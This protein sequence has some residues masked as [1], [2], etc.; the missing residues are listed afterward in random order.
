[1]NADISG[2]AR[3]WIFGV[4]TEKG[5]ELRAYDQSGW[6]II[7]LNE[8]FSSDK[9]DLDQVISPA[10][11]F[12]LNKEALSQA[13]SSGSILRTVELQDGIYVITFRGTPKTLRFNANTGASIDP[14]A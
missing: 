13:S 9:I 7:P 8:T 5:N 12:E 6:T 1:M 2:N 3:V 11:L 4:Q 10:S 14:K